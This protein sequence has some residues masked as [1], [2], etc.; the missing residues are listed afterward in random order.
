MLTALRRR[1]ML[2]KKN[3][4]SFDISSHANDSMFPIFTIR[5]GDTYWEMAIGKHLSCMR[6]NFISLGLAGGVLLVT[7]YGILFVLFIICMKI[8]TKVCYDIMDGL[9]AG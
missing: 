3:L 5:L 6:P 9:I 8:R 7:G 2:R 4:V 1:P